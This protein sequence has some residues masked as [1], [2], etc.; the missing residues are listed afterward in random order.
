MAWYNAGIQSLK[1]SNTI[2]ANIEELGSTQGVPEAV[3][4]TITLQCYERTVGP[5][6]D[7]LKKY[8]AFS[9]NTYGELLAPLL[10]HIAGTIGLNET[11]VLVDLGSGVGNC[12]AQLSLA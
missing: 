9:D 11:K 10:A 4:Q 2:H 8:A 5:R 1:Q 6:I 12:C 3:W 7:R